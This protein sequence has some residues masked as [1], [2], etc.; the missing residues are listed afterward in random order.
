MWE[1][2]YSE[3]FANVNGV[4]QGGV[5]SPVML[6]VYMDELIQKLKKSGLGCHIQLLTDLL[7]RAI[8]ILMSNIL[9]YR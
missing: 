6:T 7:S 4:R 9:F 5:P 2:E 8:K 3:C 1:V